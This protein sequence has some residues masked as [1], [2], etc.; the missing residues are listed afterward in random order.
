MDDK[1]TT[2]IQGSRPGRRASRDAALAALHVFDRAHPV[3]LTR[4]AWE[5]P[6]V[7]LFD[8]AIQALTRDLRDR[9]EEHTERQ[10][11]H[12]NGRVLRSADAAAVAAGR[13]AAG[14]PWLAGQLYRLTFIDRGASYRAL[15]RDAGLVQTRDALTALR[16]ALYRGVRVQARSAGKRASGAA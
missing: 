15:R 2:A 16:W 6:E 14:T 13:L 4:D 10:R 12:A 3:R 8:R 1:G 11:D 9:D 7:A 5:I